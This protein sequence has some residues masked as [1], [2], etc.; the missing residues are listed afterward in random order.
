MSLS[1]SLSHSHPGSRPRKVSFPSLNPRFHSLRLRKRTVPA[2]SQD[3]ISLARNMATNVLAS[4]PTTTLNN[5]NNIR[6]SREAID[7][8]ENNEDEAILD[9]F[10]LNEIKDEDEAEINSARTS[11]EDSGRLLPSASSEFLPGKLGPRPTRSMIYPYTFLSESR[12]LNTQSYSTLS[13]P[14]SIFAS[15]EPASHF[16]LKDPTVEAAPPLISL[17]A[18]SQE[19]LECD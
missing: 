19:Q 17:S 6:N 9:D 7:T 4:F 15:Y 5:N 11:Q 12:K 1:S 14:R 16:A 3:S 8:A 2:R 18:V 10:N 13:L